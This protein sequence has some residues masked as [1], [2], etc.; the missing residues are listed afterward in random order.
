MK[1]TPPHPR[2]EEIRFTQNFLHSPALVARLVAL[3]GLKRGDTVLE[4][5]PG[6]GIITRKLAEAVG[7]E[8]KVIA[9]ELD[10]GLAE[11]LRAA[12]GDLTQVGIET[13]DILR[14]RLA[15]L[16][17]GY[18]VFA[19]VPFNITSALLEMLLN[20][21]S[22]P[23]QAHLILQRETLIGSNEQGTNAETFKS[24][25]IK[26]VY[27]IE[28]AYTF[29]RSD[30][31]PQPSVETALFAFTKREPPLVDPARYGLYKDF[32]AVVSKDRF[33]EG[34]WRRLFSTA[35]LRTL[36]ERAGFA[37]A[38]GLKSQTAEAMAAAFQLFA[39]G[40]AA[41]TGAV[42]GAMA[43]LRDEQERREHINRAG[44]HRRPKR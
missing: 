38:R 20:P 3:A 8:G 12:L 21:A 26:P 15:D 9:V 35:Q 18:K 34:A 39:A 30:F 36:E 19:N 4:A 17:R 27:R 44:G 33:G 6:K 41:K 7:S 23:E 42:N 5:G 16:P 37:A 14:F 24:L 28:T 1:P 25:M 31:S 13:L 29:A 10:S 43:A 32:L 40:S 11:K 2:H 22:G